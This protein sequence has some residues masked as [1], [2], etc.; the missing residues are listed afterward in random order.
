MKESRHGAPHLHGLVREQVEWE[1]PVMVA[2]AY[3]IIVLGVG[4]MGSAAMWHLAR[5]GRRVLGLERFDI[6]HTMGSSHGANRIIRLAYFEDPAYVPLLRRA[7]EN[8]RELEARFGETLL[9][10]TGSADAGPVDG[11]VVAGS[12]RAC[13]EHGLPHEFLTARELNRR[14]PGYRLPGRYGAV[15]Q[16]EGG[17]VAS[18][19]AIVAHVMLAQTM[20]AELRARERALAWTPT[21]SGGVRVRTERGTYEAGRL[22]VSAGAW[23]QDFVPALRGRAV[24]ERQV[25]GWFQPLDSV[26]FTPATFPVFVL[27]ADEG[28]FYGFPVWSVPGFK[29]GLDHHLRETGEADAIDRDIHAR[30]EAVLRVALERY[31]PAANGPTMALR[32]CLYT[33]VSDE[34]FVIDTLPD[35]P[36][37]VVASPCS[38]HG[39]KFCS[40]IGEVLADL[41]TEGCTRFDLSSFRLSRL[42]A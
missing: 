9:F 35:S 12:L 22:V 41:A 31:F 11:P 17:F 1:Y 26:L 21:P 32:T 25:I 34:H 27:Q 6:P 40:V 38:G 4:G 42:A 5:R 28:T 23:I 3:D 29:I 37:V 15:L 30:D 13:H 16:P 10:I 36:Q 20:G 18:E 39:Y 33:N 24:P 2:S 8:W 7:Y 19:R 14:F